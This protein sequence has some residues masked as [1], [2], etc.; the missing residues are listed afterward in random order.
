MF[1]RVPGAGHHAADRLNLREFASESEA[2]ELIH[3][4]ARANREAGT[5]TDFNPDNR[6]DVSTLARQNLWGPK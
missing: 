1:R 4:R 6:R 3:R 5:V 2:T